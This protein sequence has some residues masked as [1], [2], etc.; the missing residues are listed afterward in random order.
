MD[1][2]PDQAEHF[3]VHF[4]G[5]DSEAVVEYDSSLLLESYRQYA[6]VAPWDG[7]ALYRL[8]QAD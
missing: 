7:N 6:L 3:E 5:E 4:D 8:A 1:D 2:L